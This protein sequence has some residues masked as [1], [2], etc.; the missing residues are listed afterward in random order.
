MPITRTLAELLRDYERSRDKVL[1][2]AD[3]ADSFLCFDASATCSL[4]AMET[5]F[6]Q[7]LSI[8]HIASPPGKRAPRLHDLRH[9]FAVRRLLEWY[10]RGEDAQNRLPLLSTYLGHASIADTQVYLTATAELLE[11]ANHR[12]DSY[13]GNL[14]KSDGGQ[15]HE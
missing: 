11:Q 5:Y 6:R 13:A 9:S 14:V 10:R 12:F 3:S 15:S 1:G 4:D 8:A 7:A 2:L